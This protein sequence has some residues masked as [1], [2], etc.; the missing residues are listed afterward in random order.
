MMGST[1]FASLC[2]MEKRMTPELGETK[3]ETALRAQRRCMHVSVSWDIPFNGPVVCKCNDCGLPLRAVEKRPMNP[4]EPAVTKAEVAEREHLIPHPS[5]LNPKPGITLESA[6]M[7]PI[8]EV[9]AAVD[10]MTGTR[11]DPLDRYFDGGCD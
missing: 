11:A 10:A 5:T 6:R 1:I 3:S 4:N 7:V 8:S 2:A 9:Q